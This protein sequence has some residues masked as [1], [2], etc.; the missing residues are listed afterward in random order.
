MQTNRSLFKVTFF[1]AIVLL[2]LSSCGEAESKLEKT[3][4]ENNEEQEVDLG[5]SDILGTKWI[6]QEDSS[7]A[8]IGFEIE[9]LKDAKGFFDNFD[10]TFKVS[11]K[12][13]SNAKL[14]VVIDVSSINTENS[15]RDKALME[16]DFF[17]TGKYPT[18]TFFSKNITKEENQ[19]IANGIVEMMGVK[20][21]LSFY[22]K[23]KGITKN[24]SNIDVA[25]FEGEFKIDRTMFGMTHTP[26]VGDQVKVHFYCELVS[27]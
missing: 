21:E 3:L 16:D 22:F 14:K 7:T 8:E 23:H 19:Y 2:A 25:I 11:E 10:I 1:T 20:N 9:G 24:K 27:K 17:N 13:Q 26:S 12:G 5:F 15:M 4:I 18:I 6:N